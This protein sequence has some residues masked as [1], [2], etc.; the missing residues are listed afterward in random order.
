ARET[1]RGRD[2]DVSLLDTSIAML[3]Y[4]ATNTLNREEEPQRLSA[5]GHPALYPSQVFETSDGYVA[6]ICFK[7]KFWRELCDVMGQPDLAEEP[8]FRT[9]SDRLANRDEL[10]RI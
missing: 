2:V 8:R 5:C 4:L 6:L 9:F 3:S 7:E 10:L 1:G